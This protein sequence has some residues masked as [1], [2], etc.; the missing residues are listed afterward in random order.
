MKILVSIDEIPK[1]LT[2]PKGTGAARFP[3]STGAADSSLARSSTSPPLS[4]EMRL[5][6]PHESHPFGPVWPSAGGSSRQTTPPLRVSG[7]VYAAVDRVYGA[8]QEV[9]DERRGTG[10]GG[11][12]GG[13]G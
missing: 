8:R 1:I 12:E 13:V 4:G 11:V 5:K 9:H 7:F 2:F 3:T 6:V 10:G